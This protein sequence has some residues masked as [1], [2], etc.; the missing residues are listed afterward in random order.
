MK[1]GILFDCDG[2]IL[3]SEELFSLGS[4]DHLHALS[5]EP[6]KEDTEDYAGVTMEAYCQKMIDKYHISQ[7]LKEYVADEW[8][9]TEPYFKDENLKIMPYLKD[10][11]N[12]AKSRNL[13]MAIVSSSTQSYLRHILELFEIQ[14][15]FDFVL[16]GDMAERSKPFPDIY[17]KAA[18]KTGLLKN[19]LFV[20]EDST[21]GIAAAKAAGIYV[22]GY[23]GSKIIQDTS[24]ADE[25]VFSFKEIDLIRLINR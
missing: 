15:Y 2:V 14:D 3:D 19:E 11:L 13:K 23:K 24:Q 1:K 20:I 9:Y 10:F 17:L 22:V 6:D 5:I 16:S 7:S 4:L 21:A 25:E 12:E 8:R 18:E